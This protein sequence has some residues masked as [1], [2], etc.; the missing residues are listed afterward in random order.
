[1][2]IGVSVELSNLKKCFQDRDIFSSVS[3]S[4]AG[5]ECL[6]VTGK[7]GSGKST[8]L[9]I[10]AG[11]I[12]PTCGQVNLFFTGRKLK[13]DEFNQY[14]SMVSPEMQVY[15]Y[16]T[17]SENIK[18]LGAAAG[19]YRKGNTISAALE[20][21]GLDRYRDKSVITFSTGM[22]QRLKLALLIALDRPLW[23]MD[24][25]SSNLDAEG[26]ELVTQLIATGLK[27]KKTIILATNETTEA[28]N[29]TKTIALA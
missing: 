9:K 1:M 6:A 2:D 19:V 20:R 27:D 21:V 15:R 29:A 13:K 18:F 11:L 5:G 14:V 17:A 24:E 10:V 4:I 22:K 7:N 16:L 25:P 12:R 8:L 28:G 3:T 23:L 26:R